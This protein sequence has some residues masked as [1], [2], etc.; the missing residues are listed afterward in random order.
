MGLLWLIQISNSSPYATGVNYT[1]PFYTL[2]L[3]LNIIMTVAIVARLLL[4]RHRISSALGPGHGTQYTS[5]AAMVV[6]S[7]AIYSSFSIV[8]LILFAINNPV[9]TVFLQSLGEIQV[10]FFKFGA[11]E[12]V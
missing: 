1:I 7:A 10:R 12:I 2:S 8:F 11:T 5:I 9:S 6:E 4:F 3:A